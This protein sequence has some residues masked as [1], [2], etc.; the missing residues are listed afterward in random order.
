MNNLSQFKKRLKVGVKLETT[1]TKLGSFGVRPVSIVQS[2]SFALT[3]VKNLPDGGTETV[4]SWCQY[5]KASDIEFPDADT[6]NIYWGEGERR[7]H[8]LTYKF[9]D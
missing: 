6:A 5:P 4:N 9:V 1:H 3:T 7:E 8:I 2:N